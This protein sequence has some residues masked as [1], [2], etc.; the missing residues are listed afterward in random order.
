MN[1][2]CSTIVYNDAT[3]EILVVS[4]WEDHTDF[5]IPGGRLDLFIDN[6]I[7]DAAKREVL[8]ETG[9]I[10]DI[11]NLIYSAYDEYGFM[12]YTFI[13]KPAS[14]DIKTE[15][16]HLVIWTKDHDIIK[17]GRY[18]NYNIPMLESFKNYLNIQKWIIKK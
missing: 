14:F 18:K 11:S 5:G 1:I 2:G 8:E 10:V 3:D 16:S 17:N 12:S 4:R 7:A 6:S 15:E 13:G 9:I